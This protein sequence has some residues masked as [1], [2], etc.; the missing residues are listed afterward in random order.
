[1][2]NGDS[3]AKPI[4]KIVAPEQVISWNDPLHE[5]PVPS[6]VELGEV[7]AKFLSDCGWGAYDDILADLEKRDLAVS[8]AE[9]L[10]LWFE[11]DLYDQLQLIQI[12]D[13]VHGKQVWLIQADDYL[14]H[15]SEDQLRSLWKH[16]VLVDDAQFELATQAW[17][18]FRSESAEPLRDLVKLD[19]KGLRHLRA[20]LLRHLED[21]PSDIG[22]LGRTDRQI[23]QAVSEGSSTF[24]ELFRAT[25]AMEQAIYMG[26]SVFKLHLDRLAPLVGFQEPFSLTLE[27]KRVL[28]IE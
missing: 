11:H 1:M 18:A 4:E 6:G 20:A 23:L 9:T 8:K 26:D 22:D 25:Q 12:L 16:P 15:M 28:R 13:L 7:R 14:G 24:K 2:T 10:T 3:A 17:R 5:G 21:V 27:G 19:L